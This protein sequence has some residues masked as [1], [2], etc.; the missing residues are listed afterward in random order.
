MGL[1]FVLGQTVTF[2][3]VNHRGYKKNRT[4]AVEALRF[5][6][7]AYYPEPQWILFGYCFHRADSRGFALSHIIGQTVKPL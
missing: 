4:V 7:T 1:N 3:Y 6:S 2:D 5:T